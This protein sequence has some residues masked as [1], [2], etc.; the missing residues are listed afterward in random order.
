MPT[1]LGKGNEMIHYENPLVCCLFA[2]YI[3]FSFVLATL[4]LYFFFGE[5]TIQMTKKYCT[6]VDSGREGFRRFAQNH[7]LQIFTNL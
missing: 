3:V 7:L 5:I 6:D 4:A 2:N 1:V